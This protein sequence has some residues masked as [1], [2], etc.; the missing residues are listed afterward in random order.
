M[1]KSLMGL[2]FSSAFGRSILAVADFEL[3]KKFRFYYSESKFN[4]VILFNAWLRV[5][6]HLGLMAYRYRVGQANYTG[7]NLHR[8]HLLSDR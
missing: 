6:R 7:K 1:C 4:N 2:S 8:K 5:S 3:L